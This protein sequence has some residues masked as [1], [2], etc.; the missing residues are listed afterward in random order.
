MFC[1]DACLNLFLNS[2][3]VYYRISF[4]KMINTRY[5]L[6]SSRNFLKVDRFKSAQSIK[7]SAILIDLNSSQNNT[8]QR[9]LF[10]DAVLGVDRFLDHRQRTISHFGKHKSEFKKFALG[11]K[12]LFSKIN[13]VNV[14][15][16]ICQVK[17][18]LSC[19]MT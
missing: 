6:N 18:V 5:I 4:P 7:A 2:I 1:F 12:S 13:S 11:F 3:F 17:M 9:T 16:N 19:Q 15:K 10:T 8:S 14:F